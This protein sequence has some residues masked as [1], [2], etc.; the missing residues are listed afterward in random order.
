MHR[1]HETASSVQVVLRLYLLGRVVI[2]VPEFCKMGF[3][4]LELYR[5]VHVNPHE[6]AGLAPERFRQRLGVRE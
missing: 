4:K 3:S 1:R 2:F 6:F 5:V